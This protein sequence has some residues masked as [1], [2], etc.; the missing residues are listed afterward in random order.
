MWSTACSTAF[1]PARPC[2]TYSSACVWRSRASPNS[3]ATKKPLAATSRRAR[4]I[5]PAVTGPAYG[6]R[7]GGRD[8]AAR[9][10]DARFGGLGVRQRG[11]H[12]GRVAVAAGDQ[13]VACLTVGLRQEAGLHP[14]VH[15]LRVVGDDRDRGLLGL[16]GVAAAQAQPDRGRV[17]QP[18]DLLVLGLLRARG[19][20]PRVAPALVAV[21]A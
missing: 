17:E 9:R 13:L 18:E 11:T 4:R 20:A 21:D 12:V 19:V 5:L 3:T 1:E 2:R 15:G 16:D 10:S 14:E 6:T 8:R 7:P